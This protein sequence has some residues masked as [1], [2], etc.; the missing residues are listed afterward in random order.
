MAPLRVNVSAC[1]YQAMIGVGGIGSG[2]FFALSG[3]HTLG[4]E[5]SRSGRFLE[6]RDYCK[7]HIIAHYVQTLLGPR[8]ATVPIGKVGDDEAGHRLLQEMKDAGLDVRY[9]E[10]CPGEQTLSAIC[11]IYPDGS[12]GNLT[13][14]DS[15]CEKVDGAFVARAEPEFARFE[16]RGVALAAP[17]VPLAARKRL[18]QLGTAYRFLRVASFVSAEMR[19]AVEMGL[20]GQID[21]LAVNLDE[22]AAVVGMS[23]EGRSP[24]AIVETAV[25]RLHSINPRMSVSITAGKNG[26]W[27]WD[28]ASLVHVPVF[29]AQVVNTAGAGDAH[30]SGVIAG[31]VAGLAMV[32][33]QE[34]GTLVAGLSVTSPHTIAPEVERQ[35]LRTFANRSQ[36]PLSGAV[37]ALLEDV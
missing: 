14:D 28:G 6:R 16:G 37:R 34:L 12:G 2:V 33:A 22:A 21:L 1:C 13:V 4:R 27:S 5:E 32:Q 3:D 15:A 8:F 36:A 11:L 18:L 24:L 19:A 25:E 35:S 17:E 7:L 9:V 20:L 30:L 10:S 26:S 29:P 31:L 23:T